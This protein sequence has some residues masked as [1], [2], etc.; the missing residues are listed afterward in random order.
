VLLKTKALSNIGV[1]FV[2]GS[3]LSVFSRFEVRTPI[4]SFCAIVIAIVCEY[5]YPLV[6][7]MIGW[8][9]RKGELSH[10]KIADGSVLGT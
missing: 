1:L 4:D 10:R 2:L 8:I 7:I 6:H 9:S 5:I 3:W